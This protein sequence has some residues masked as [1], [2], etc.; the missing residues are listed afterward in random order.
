MKRGKKNGN[1][2]FDLPV[3]TSAKA[4]CLAHLFNYTLYYIATRIEKALGPL[5]LKR[6]THWC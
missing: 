4:G 6:T 2:V 1:S 3:C 5:I